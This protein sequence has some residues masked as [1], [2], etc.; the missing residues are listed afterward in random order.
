MIH[1][2]TDRLEDLSD[3]LRSVGDRD[4]SFP[5]TY[6]RG[7]GAMHPGAKDPRDGPGAGPRGRSVRDIFV[8]DLRLG[9]GI[10]VPTRNFRQ[11]SG[12]PPPMLTRRRVGSGRQ[13]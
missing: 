13:C 11:Y 3:L 6:G 4:E 5:V 7:D 12:L 1:V 10:K 2:I 8:P 9:S